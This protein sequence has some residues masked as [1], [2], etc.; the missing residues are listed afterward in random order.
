MAAAVGTYM[1]KIPVSQLEIL[2][3]KPSGD[4]AVMISYRRN[5]EPQIRDIP[6]VRGDDGW[7]VG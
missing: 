7:K 2:G 4:D 3:E 6:L 1:N 5:G